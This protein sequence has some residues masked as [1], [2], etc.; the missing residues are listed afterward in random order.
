[1]LIIII[2]IVIIIII[3]QDKNGSYGSVRTLLYFVVIT[4]FVCVQFIT[5]ISLQFNGITNDGLHVLCPALTPFVNLTAFDLAANGIVLTSGEIG[6]PLVNVLA[7]ALAS[8]PQL[9]RLNL[10]GIRMRECVSLILGNI[11]RP[12]SMLRLSSCG[13]RRTDLVW[14][15]TANI[16]SELEQLD[17]GGNNVAPHV[18]VLCN[19]LKHAG[20]SLAVFE[21][22]DAELTTV[23]LSLLLA[24]FEHLLQLRYVNVCGS[25]DIGA[26]AVIDTLEK[27][28]AVPRLR[29]FRL[30]A[31]K[32]LAVSA[33]DGGVVHAAEADGGVNSDDFRQAQ[34]SFAWRLSDLLARL[35]HAHSRPVIRLVF[36]L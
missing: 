18:D 1:L 20:N 17:I 9:Q 21:A 33:A 2:I 16:S 19:L 7:N 15:S 10:S 32:D 14:L 11:S 34:N 26:A 24:T 22:E 3:T 5:G 28:I 27:L 29:M 23:S 30:S 31:P 25:D 8:L 13:L 36:K 6:R 35:C 12:L 4:V